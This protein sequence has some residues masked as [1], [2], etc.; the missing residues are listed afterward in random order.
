MSPF[1]IW[2]VFDQRAKRAGIRH[3]FPHLARHSTV[4]WLREEGR[5]S[6]EVRLLTGQTEATIENVYS[7]VRKR[8]AIADVLPSL[9]GRL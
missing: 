4:T 7:H 3:V 2:R 1:Q 9:R 8:G 5:S 6:A